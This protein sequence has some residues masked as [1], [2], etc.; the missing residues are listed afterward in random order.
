MY[1][2]HFV[3]PGAFY[4]FLHSLLSRMVLDFCALRVF[5]CKRSAS[6]IGAWVLQ[7]KNLCNFILLLLQLTTC[8]LLCN[9]T[10]I[11][12]NPALLG[13]TLKKKLLLLLCQ[14]LGI[15]ADGPLKQGTALWGHLETA[16]HAG[17]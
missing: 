1:G 15:A 11:P 17:R 9:E 13:R 4:C 6:G 14:F 5:W 10:K 12:K 8:R 2:G 16:I 7:N 3:A